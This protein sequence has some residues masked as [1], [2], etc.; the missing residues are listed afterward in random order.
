MDF[1]NKIAKE[2]QLWSVNFQMQ[3]FSL[4]NSKGTNLNIFKAMAVMAIF[5]GNLKDINQ[6]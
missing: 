6:L 5:G 4:I 2:A 1:T 3:T